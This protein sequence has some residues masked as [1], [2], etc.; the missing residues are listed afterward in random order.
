MTFLIFWILMAA[1]VAIIA[2]HKGF[3]WIGWALYALAIWPIALVHVLVKDRRNQRAIP[4]AITQGLT[5]TPGGPGA[6]R[7][8]TCPECAEQVLAAAKVCRFCR[9][10]FTLDRS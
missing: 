8:K 9:H 6:P 5:A 7:M 3:N 4:V 10:N 1:I 2:G